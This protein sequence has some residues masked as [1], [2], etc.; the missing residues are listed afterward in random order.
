[1]I[2]ARARAPSNIA[3]VKYMGKTEGNL[4]A[5][6]SVSMTLD[7]LCSWAELRATGAGARELR[8]S[9]LSP[10][11]PVGAG[12][13]PRLDSAGIDRVLA[14]ARRALEAAP[15]ALRT[16]GLEPRELA[17]TLELLTSNT[18]PASAGIASSASSFAAV[19][20][21]AVKLRAADEGAFARAWKAEPALRRACAAISRQGSGSSCR[22]FE[23]P[24]VRWDGESA[25]A[26]SSAL[27]ELS[28]F[29]VV[30]SEDAKAVGSSEAHRRV[31]TS[32]QWA[33][34][35]ERA[36]R[37]CDELVSALARRDLRAVARLAW[38]DAWEM[39]GLFHTSV[40]PFSYWKPATIDALHALAP[41]VARENP[42]I[43]TLDAGPNLHVIVERA[44]EGE[45][46]ARLS[47]L[48]GKLLEDRPG[49]G[50]E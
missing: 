43:V 34:R 1:L 22:S 5:N 29:V 48:G 36:A 19:T 10:S 20:L 30:V 47:D 45:W 25:R 26:V 7:G 11:G 44:R 3:L 41:F 14:H 39:H 35:P 6:P 49:G 23:G 32:P 17:G 28:H 16:A 15:G 12:A 31:R 37:R 27:P 42:P 2:S 24:F 4:P 50:A 9:P 21:A 40:P 38:L 33:T 8:Y 46:R 18:F 13:P